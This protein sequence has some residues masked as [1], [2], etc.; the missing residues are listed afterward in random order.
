MSNFPGY[1]S[2]KNGF[3]CRLLLNKALKHVQWKFENIE[4]NP[5]YSV[6]FISSSSCVQFVGLLK[7]VFFSIAWC[8]SQAKTFHNQ[9]TSNLIVGIVHPVS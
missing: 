7:H 4:Y 9:A 1:P 8:S 3:F 6:M 2:R 5:F